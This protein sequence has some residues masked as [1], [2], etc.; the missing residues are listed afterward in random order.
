MNKL[1]EYLRAQWLAY[2]TRKAD[3]AY[4]DG[5]CWAAGELL[6]GRNPG[7]I[8]DLMGADYFDAGVADACAAWER[9]GLELPA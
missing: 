5:W 8:A 1:I 9:R 7:R 2:R 6:H 3:E 4:E